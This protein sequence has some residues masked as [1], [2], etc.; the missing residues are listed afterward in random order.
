MPIEAIRSS[1]KALMASALRTA[2]RSHDEQSNINCLPHICSSPL[3]SLF[4]HEGRSPTP[5]PVSGGRGRPSAPAPAAVL[6]ANQSPL[7]KDEWHRRPARVLDQADAQPFV[8]FKVYFF[9]GVASALEEAPGPS[10]RTAAGAGVKCDLFLVHHRLR[11][12]RVSGPAQ[13][14]PRALRGEGGQPFIGARL[15]V[16]PKPPPQAQ[17]PRLAPDSLGALSDHV[18]LE[19]REVVHVSLLSPPPL[20]AELWRSRIGERSPNWPIGDAHIASEGNGRSCPQEA[21]QWQRGQIRS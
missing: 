1:E 6:A 13:Q 12:T 7:E 14:R 21:A 15:A 18:P 3:Y 11:L 8:T 20:H 9:E 16:L 19:I 4:P 5:C 2:S 17:H 10:A